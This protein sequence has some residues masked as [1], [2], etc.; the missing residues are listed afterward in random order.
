MDDAAPEPRPLRIDRLC[1]PEVARRFRVDPRLILPVGTTLQH[2]P[3]LPLCTDSVIAAR[4]A[5]ALA[6]QQDVLVAPT[7]VYGACSRRD[8]EYAGTAALEQKTLHRVLND[9]VGVWEQQGVDEIYLLTAHGYGPHISAIATVVSERARIRAIDLHSADLSPLLEDDGPE[10][11]GEMETSL[12]LHYAPE[13]VRRDEIRDQRVSREELT[14]L[15]VGEEP[16]P[17]PGSSG[18]VGA[19]SLASPEK[20]RRIHDHLVQLFGDRLFDGS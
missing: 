7:L 4:L 11:A 12:M 15:T 5:E 18:T 1:W 16:I 20:G 13:L 8:G 10:H 14:R 6:R 17:R 3:H 19:P 2:G 9:L